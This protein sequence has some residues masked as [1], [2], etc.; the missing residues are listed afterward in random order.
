MQNED[1]DLIEKLQDQLPYIE[2]DVINQMAD[3][4]ESLLSD[5]NNPSNTVLKIDQVLCR[6]ISS[7]LNECIS[8]SAGADKNSAKGE[9]DDSLFSRE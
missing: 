4:F 7:E 1:S 9:I 6:N 2:N 8:K 3:I 5:E